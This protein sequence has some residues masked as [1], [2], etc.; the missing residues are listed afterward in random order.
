LNGDQNVT[1]IQS[2]NSSLSGVFLD[3][4]PKYKVLVIEAGEF[5]EMCK[6]NPEMNAFFYVKHYIKNVSNVKK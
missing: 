3:L 5:L 6:I 4:L 2:S 1:K